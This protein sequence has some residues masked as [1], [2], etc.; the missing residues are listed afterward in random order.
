MALGGATLQLM[1]SWC[2][3]EHE[4]LLL[5]LLVII[6]TMVVLLVLTSP[7]QPERPMN[8][9]ATERNSLT[10]LRGADKLK[11]Y[12]VPGGW[13]YCLFYSQSACNVYLVKT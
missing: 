12:Q 3:R 11:T 9:I 13:H 5:K 10:Y 2:S 6:F 8:T 4:K 7:E 1:H